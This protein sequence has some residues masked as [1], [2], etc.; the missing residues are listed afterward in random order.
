MRD[1][2]RIYFCGLQVMLFSDQT[3][4]KL[5]R[6]NTHLERQKLQCDGEW[7]QPRLM[8]ATSGTPNLESYA[9]R[10]KK[11]CRQQR[12]M[13]STHV[14]SE[15]QLFMPWLQQVHRVLWAQGYPEERCM[16]MCSSHITISCCFLGMLHRPSGTSQTWHDKDVGQHLVKK[17]S[18][19]R[20]RTCPSLF[21]P[22]LLTAEWCAA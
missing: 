16:F 8:E 17:S 3:C 18:P 12:E 6:F 2:T 9:Q 10:E 19:M 5:K 4:P 13:P 15:S 1:S 22:E 7:S 20:C 14:A 21:M 11:L